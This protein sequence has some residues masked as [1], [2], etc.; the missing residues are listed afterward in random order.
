MFGLDTAE[1]LAQVG[2]FLQDHAAQH[3]SQKLLMTFAL[4]FHNC[5]TNWTA[6]Y[7]KDLWEIYHV[8]MTRSIAIKMYLSLELSL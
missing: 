5:K 1:W 6:V 3:V 8:N 2:E 7:C 4:L